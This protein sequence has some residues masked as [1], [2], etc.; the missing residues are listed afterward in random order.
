MARLATYSMRT[1]RQSCTLVH[2]TS[3]EL[4][5]ST[6]RCVADY[7]RALDRVA[8]SRHPVGDRR[9][10]LRKIEEEEVYYNV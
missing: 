10:A 3:R 6:A 4:E 2:N 8:P 5:P 7:E 9:R 1:Q